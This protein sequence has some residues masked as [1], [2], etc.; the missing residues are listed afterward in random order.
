MK[1]IKRQISAKDG[2]G[3]VKLRCEEGEDMWHTFH[4]VAVGDRLRTTTLRKVVKEGSTGS[5]TSEKKKLTLTIEVAQVNFDAESCTL[6]VAGVN[7]EESPHVRL[8]AYHTVHLE[9]QRDFTLSK[10]RWDIVCLDRLAEAADPVR[11]AEVAAVA[12]E[13]TGLAHVCLIGGSMTVTRAKIEVSIP[14]KRAGASGHGKAVER[15]YRA[16]HAAVSKHVDFTTIKAVL[17][18]SPGFV[19]ADF[20]EHMF[21]E[22]VR[23]GERPIIENRAKF[24]L[25]RASSGHKRAV[26]EMLENPAVAGQLLETR[27]VADVRAFTDFSRMLGE[28][29][30]RAY[31][32]FNHVKVR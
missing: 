26:G 18:G 8:G 1:I 31:Y 23:Q 15:F 20:L 7:V 5:V 14:K 22:A 6:H 2:E 32:G 9:L 24:V 11:G 16:V 29:P 13:G 10:D 21:A 19:G 27:V 28:D 12:M 4:L 3:S 17:V 25:C 30:D